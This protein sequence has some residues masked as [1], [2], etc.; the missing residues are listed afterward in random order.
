MAESV[1][2]VPKFCVPGLLKVIVWACGGETYVN[3]VAAPVA[4]VPPAVLTVTST[5]P[6][7]GGSVA[8]ICVSLFTVATA[9]VVPNFTTVPAGY[10]AAV[11]PVPLMMTVP[12]PAA[13]PLAGDTPLTAGCGAIPR[14][15]TAKNQSALEVKLTWSTSTSPRS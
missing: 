15:S 9:V 14:S 11:N 1:G 8:V 6:E 4:L 5:T 3:C 7:P 13:A 12:P 2:E 10:P